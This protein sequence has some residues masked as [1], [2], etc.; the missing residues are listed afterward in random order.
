MKTNFRGPQTRARAVSLPDT[1]PRYSDFDGAKLSYAERLEA[2][3]KLL[4]AGLSRIA[5][6]PSSGDCGFCHSHD[7]G[8]HKSW[9]PRTIAEKHLA[10]ATA[11]GDREEKTQW[12]RHS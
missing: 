9:C 8:S 7:E 12:T 4:R 5:S 6:S 2:E 10:V 1:V 3:I 11:V